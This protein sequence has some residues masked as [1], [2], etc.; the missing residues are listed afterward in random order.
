MPDVIQGKRV[1]VIDDS[2]VRGN[3]T[4]KIVRLLKDA[5]AKEIHVRISS[6]PM[7]FPCFFGVT[8]ISES[9][10]INFCVILQFT[11]TKIFSLFL[12]ASQ[13]TVKNKH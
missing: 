9:G 12:V 2:I 4:G 3:T 8:K 1:I 13:Q 7:K 5:G 6:P 10:V 11:G